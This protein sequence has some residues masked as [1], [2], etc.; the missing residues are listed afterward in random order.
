[1]H[2]IGLLTLGL[3]QW[4]RDTGKDIGDMVG[5]HLKKVAGD[6]ALSFAQEQLGLGLADELGDAAKAVASKSVSHA[7]DKAGDVT[8]VASA[9]AAAKSVGDVAKQEGLA[10]LTNLAGKYFGGAGTPEQA[11]KAC[12]YNV[13]T[14]RKIVTKFRRDL[15][16]MSV[17]EF[18]RIHSLIGIQTNTI[19]AP[20][21]RP[22]AERLDGYLAGL[23][24]SPRQ[25]GFT[26]KEKRDMVRRL[27]KKFHSKPVSKMNRENLVRMIYGTAYDLSINWEPYFE[28]EPQARR[29]PKSCTEAIGPGSVRHTDANVLPSKGPKRA[30]NAYAKFVKEMMSSFNFP[31]GT[32]QTDK[33]K[34]ISKEWR[35][36]KENILDEEHFAEVDRE[37]RIEGRKKARAARPGQKQRLKKS[38]KIARKGVDDDLD[39]TRADT[40][41]GPPGAL[42]SKVPTQKVGKQKRRILDD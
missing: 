23:E 29:I 6:K 4:L 42:R 2:T 16:S 26:M 22:F 21:N 10:Q 24:L 20:K 27:K 37:D 11:V 19:R 18:L 9:K 40:T 41:P 33:M 38:F 17:D 34:I 7:L 15:N 13:T 28:G 32:K 39:L 14:L 35:K 8:D 30:P 36:E 3:N 12:L 5:D 25:G 1:M 31:S